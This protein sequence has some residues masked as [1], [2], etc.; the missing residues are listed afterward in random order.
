MKKRFL[1]GVL[2]LLLA[3]ECLCTPLMEARAETV[4]VNAIEGKTEQEAEAESESKEEGTAET[5]ETENAKKQG[6]EKQEAT[7]V[8]GTVSQNTTAVLPDGF[9]EDEI[10]DVPDPNADADY[11]IQYDLI[12][13]EVL[14]TQSEREQ[15]NAEW[16]SFNADAA[17]LEAGT[18]Y[19]EGSFAF[20]A[21]SASEAKKIANIY[22]AK[23]LGYSYG[24]GEMIIPE[25]TTKEVI[26]AC[27]DAV[28]GG[29]GEELPAIYPNGIVISD[30]KLSEENN[31]ELSISGNEA[32]VSKNAVVE[33]VSENYIVE[34]DSVATEVF[35]DFMNGEPIL[36]EPENEIE[37]KPVELTQ[38]EIDFYK[39]QSSIYEENKAIDDVPLSLNEDGS[40]T[41]IGENFYGQDNAEGDVKAF[42]IYGDT[43]DWYHT[44]NGD[45]EAWNTA[46][47]SGVNVAVI[48]SGATTSHPDLAY[49]GS[50][51]A[52]TLN[53]SG[54]NAYLYSYYYGGSVNGAKDNHGHGTHVAG[55]IAA[56][57]GNGG[58]C[59]VAPGAKIISIK[60]LEYL[61][62]GAYQGSAA[63]TDA[64]VSRAIN[65]AV[66][67]GARVINM[68]L[69]GPDS[70][71]KRNAVDAA[72]NKGCVLVSAAG[73]EG[74]AT[75]NENYPGAYSNTISVAATRL[76]G[77]SD[78]VVDTYSNSGS[79]VDIA[80]PGTDIYST[81][82]SNSWGVMSGTSM[83]TPMV[84]GAIALYLENNKALLS[85]KDSSFH[86]T[87]KNA[88]INSVVDKGNAGKDNSYGYGVL[89]TKNLV[90]KI[91]TT[92][93]PRFSV[94]G[95]NVQEGYGIQMFSSNGADSI[96][97]TM[98][99]STPTENSLNFNTEKDGSGLI[100][101]PKNATSITVKAV[102]IVG[103][104]KSSV[105][106]ATFS[107]VP[108][109]IK[110]L[111][112]KYTD[113]SV[114]SK[115]GYFRSYSYI[116]SSTKGVV[117]PYQLY[118]L[119]LNP[120]DKLDVSLTAPDFNGELFILTGNA[121]KASDVRDYTAVTAKAA[122]PRT[123]SYTNAG[124]SAQEII[125]A[126]T[127]G[128]LLF[129]QTLG[130]GSGKGRY[131]FKTTITRVP[132]SIVLTLPQN[133]LIKGKTM[134]TAAD[135]R[136][137]DTTNQKLD[138]KLHYTSNNA[139]VPAD[140]ASVSTAGIVSIKNVTAP[141]AM[142]VKAVS[143]A[144]TTVFGTASFTAY[145]PVT[146]MLPKN[147]TVDITTNGAA[148]TTNAATNFTVEPANTLGKYSYTSNNSKVA[149][150][151]DTGLVSAIGN[152]KATIT[153]KALDGSGKSA[154]FAVN[155][156]TLTTS[157]KMV[158]NTNAVES[159]GYYPIPAGTSITLKADVLPVTASN[160]AVEYTAVG[161]LPT[162]VTLKGNAV[163]VNAS[164]AVNTVFTLSVKAKDGSNISSTK[165]FKVYA[166][167]AKVVLSGTK[168]D[169][170]TINAK[171]AAITASVQ[172]KEGQTANIVQAVA[173][174]S[175]NEKVATVSQTGM[176]TAIGSGS[177]TIKVTTT[178]GSKLSAAAVI[179]V[180]EG[181]TSLTIAPAGSVLDVLGTNPYPV[182]SGKATTM[183]AT[184]LPAT[185]SNKAVT[186]SL[187]SA[188]E[189]VKINASGAVSIPKTVTSGTI[190]VKAV[191]KDGLFNGTGA[192]ASKVFTIYPPAQKVTLA[193]V[194]L[195]LNTETAK[196][197]QMTATVTPETGIYSGVTWKSNN[198]KV[199]AVSATGLV[200]A[201]S[202][203][204]AVITATAKDGSGL[205]ASKTVT[206]IQPMS[207]FK[208]ENKSGMK[209]VS[210]RLILISGSNALVL[211]DIVP[212]TPSN[213]NV[214]W[215]F[216]GDTTGAVTINSSNGTVSIK[217]DKAIPNT[218]ITITAKVND[219]EKTVTQAAVI[220]PATKNIY[221]AKTDLIRSMHVGETFT[222][223][224]T[225]NPVKAYNQVNGGFSYQ[226]GN[227]KV[228]TVNTG[229][230][231]TAVSKGITFITVGAT[232]GSNKNA[233][234]MVYVYN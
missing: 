16:K 148:K 218:S 137:F 149:T 87:V 27:V 233:K 161:V 2:A 38:S 12:D 155:V 14:P 41:V 215:S 134:K 188:P 81:Y 3:A 205:K 204:S 187:V 105:A 176:V 110:I 158:P 6:T 42:L 94:N 114:L 124:A 197:T 194:N 141:T 157:V 150:V 231:V 85:V 84:S 49:A 211:K 61:A 212:V 5:V 51:S 31:S 173:W 128:R 63:G 191:A 203:G 95:G 29:T 26:S 75:A 185:A 60:A 171:T 21:K 139:E 9:G 189:G 182:I 117:M 154:A 118:T 202:K 99:G 151:T 136:P 126:V 17:S 82:L 140:V 206:V 213:K 89:N 106:S 108:Q 200:T 159:G 57:G 172:N 76:S 78:Q 93:Q 47:G 221:L 226:T 92:A 45:F 54:L 65:M 64:S 74:T 80:A 147:K 198:E 179:K 69:G 168:Y 178:D 23:L 58:A 135:I 36:E 223:S 15:R 52:F 190:T 144:R 119:T 72:V 216:T 208:I 207:S 120:Q 46:I 196:T 217:A 83:A 163:T 113:N 86:A 10:V 55:I 183:V 192:T 143:Q 170:N 24:I 166:R 199:A 219:S 109:T 101:F 28:E 11:E 184:V 18:D 107:I 175:S 70:T 19:I 79:S 133:Y 56:R 162:G 20:E 30:T 164:T 88:L 115:V 53:F 227:S 34:S 116:S 131:M 13:Q 33:A 181:V 165:S 138:W 146:S 39:N 103:K 160:K 1:A 209:D 96:Y 73:N 130:T 222:L 214:T 90:S 121:I 122:N 7:D 125:V 129:N 169:L 152:G 37:S 123:A 228:A 35:Y 66:A 67:K 77:T 112:A 229:G 167:P 68:S 232:D 44:V 91:V 220:Y 225:C 97:Y 127:S 102:S 40:I 230:V 186:W 62:Y 98:D 43:M 48:D 32:S 25:M 142:Y 50:Y 193:D 4:S 174:T 111:T 71:L 210:N 234:I 156:T 8:S 104:T 177:A 100:Y 132:Q 22:G 180:V 201:V 224:P 195:K 145:P 153:I 59:G